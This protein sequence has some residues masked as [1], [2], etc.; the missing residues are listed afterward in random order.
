MEKDCVR[1]VGVPPLNYL[2]SEMNQILGESAI[3]ASSRYSTTYQGVRK[4]TIGEVISLVPVKDRCFGK[5]LY[6]LNKDDDPKIE[7]WVFKGEDIS[8]WG[9]LNYWKLI[10]TSDNRV[11]SIK[12]PYKSLEN[13][14]NYLYELEYSNLDYNYA[15][16]YFNS[17]KVV[18]NPGACS[19]MKKD[20]FIGRYLDWYYS[21]LSEAI[22]H[23]SKMANR[24]AS[25]GVAGG[26][27]GLTQEFIESQEPS[28]LYKL[29]PF[30][31]QDG[32]N[33]KGL[34]CSMNVVPNDYGTT[35][36]TIPS[37]ELRESVCAI[38]LVRYIL[39][40]FATVSEAVDYLSNYVSVFMPKY[41]ADNGYEVHFMLSD[42]T[43]S[44]AY[45]LEFVN[46][47][48]S[49]S[50]S[51]I[52]TNFF[53]H[54]VSFNSDGSVYTQADLSQGHSPITHNGITPY[55]SGLERFNRLNTLR[56]GVEDLESMAEAMESVLYTNTYNPD[57]TPFWFSEY[58]YPKFNI[59]LNTLPNDPTLVEV[60][61]LKERDF[62]NRVRGDGK[63]WQTTHGCIYDLVNKQIH[64]FVQEDT[65]NM[66]TF[67]LKKN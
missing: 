18:F 12:D 14:T 48:I 44:E 51:N 57:T 40:N 23:T 11:E 41:L 3:N 39:D 26:L 9:N 52:M 10:L 56:E 47:Q 1:L 67:N 60:I 59:N 53:L 65:H 22:I 49:I 50:R 34:Y 64:I 33:E 61:S 54:G 36:G 66:F 42:D 46:N 17:R 6:F 30:Y 8:L 20:G 35:Y 27:E 28:M 29:L 55:G 4:F 62:E 5:V 21:L 45:I 58:V 7:Y 63:T 16:S 13:T 31:L 37:I 43:S 32:I 24:Y 19:S 2:T 15:K 38:M 25:V